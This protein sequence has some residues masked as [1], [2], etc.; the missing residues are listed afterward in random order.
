MPSEL[1]IVQENW[2]DLA[3]RLKNMPVPFEQ[4]IFLLECHVA[5]TMHVDDV[6]VKTRDVLPGTVLTL[7][8]DTGNGHDR[9]AIGVE[10]ARGERLGWMPKEHNEVFARLMDAGKLLVAKVAAKDLDDGYWLN[11]RINVYIKEV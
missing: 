9:F 5:R 3:D 7:K 2:I 6:L 11:L 10:N 4:E 8:R 1:A